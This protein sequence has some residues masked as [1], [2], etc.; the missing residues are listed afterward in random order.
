[1]DLNKPI[2][3]EWSQVNANKLISQKRKWEDYVVAWSLELIAPWDSGEKECVVP[4]EIKFWEHLN[5]D[6][7][8]CLDF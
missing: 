7:S 8:D 5:E 6:N 3:W 2:Q 4:E 1:L